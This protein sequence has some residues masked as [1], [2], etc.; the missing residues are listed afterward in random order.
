MK[1]FWRTLWEKG[2]RWLFPGW[3]G[4]L[5]LALAS[6]IV[7]IF[8]QETAMMYAFGSNE[9]SIRTEPPPE[10]HGFGGGSVPAKRMRRNSFLWVLLPSYI[11]ISGIKSVF[12]NRILSNLCGPS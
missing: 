6:G 4:A 2:K 8:S 3:K 5:P 7:A 1:L 9:N 11:F 12:L 10:P